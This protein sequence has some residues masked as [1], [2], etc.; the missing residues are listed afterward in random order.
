M[1]RTAVVVLGMHRSGT[2]A[3]A[4]LLHRDGAALPRSVMP[5]ADDNPTGFSESTRLVDLADEILA[6]HGTS[7]DGL[8]RIP[9]AWFASSAGEAWAGRYADALTEEFPGEG[10]VVIKDPRL[11]RLVPLLVEACDRAGFAPRFA[12][13]L[14]HPWAV[15][16]SLEARNGWRP[17]RGLAQWMTHTLAA[18]AGTRGRRRALV[19]YDALVDDPSAVARRLRRTLDVQR[20]RSAADVPAPDELVRPELRHH[21]E[22][23]GRPRPLRAFEPWIGRCW[24]AL[25]RLEE[26]DEDA[27]REL[28]R[29]RRVVVRVERRLTPVARD[30]EDETE[31]E[32]RQREAVQANLRHAEHVVDD[33][34]TKIRHREVRLEEAL[35]ERERV[36]SELDALAADR[37]EVQ[38]HLRF[39]ER[40]IARLEQDLETLRRSWSMRLTRPLRWLGRRARRAARMV[41]GKARS[42]AR[43]AFRALPLPD[44]LRRAIRG[45]LAR[46]RARRR[47]DEDRAA[48]ERR[49]RGIEGGILAGAPGGLA[50]DLDGKEAKEAFRRK[51]DAELDRFLD[52]AATLR[53]PDPSD[54]PALSVLLVLHDQAALTLACLRALAASEFRDFEVVVVDNAS[55]DRTRELL[56]R[57][58]PVR[59]VLSDENLHFLRGA[60]LAAD[61]A[62]G[63]HLLFL[64]NDTR[65]APSALG[66][67]LR[68]FGEE[69]RVGVVGARLILPDGRLQEAGSIVWSDGSCLGYGRGGDPDD[70][71]WTFRRDV[72]YC[73][74]AFLLTPRW[75][76]RELGGFDERFAPAYYE[77]TDYCMRVRAAGYRVVFEPGVTVA[78]FEFGSSSEEDG[79]ALQERNRGRF[80]RKHRTRLASHPEPR[81]E[82]PL[83]ARSA[84]R[85]AP[86]ILCIDDRFPHRELGSGFPRANDLVHDMVD[87][88]CEVTIYATDQRHE[89]P[90]ELRADLPPSVECLRGDRGHDLAAVLEERQGHADVVV[91]SRPHNMRAFDEVVRGRPEVFGNQRV[92]YDAEALFTLR[93]AARRRVLGDP[94]DEAE[95]RAMLADEVALAERA[96]A[97]L[98][99]N[100]AEARH[101]EGHGAEVFVVGHALRP[102]PGE[103]GFEERSGMLFV[104]AFHGDDDGP[105][106]DSVRWFAGEVWPRIRARRDVGDVRFRIVGRDPGPAVAALDRI[107]GVEVV[108]PVDRLGPAYGRARVCVVPTRFAAGMPYKAHEAAAR[109]VPMVTT[110]LIAEQLGWTHDREILVADASDPEAFADRCVQ[111]HADAELWAR[112]RRGALERVE[113]ECSPERTRRELLRA[114]GLDEEQLAGARPWRVAAEAEAKEASTVAGR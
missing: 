68:V 114:L 55:T 89:P 76:F 66:R 96:D 11:C 13:S 32:R 54:P 36:R 3:L 93:K 74:G 19:C 53:L 15:A 9:P 60:A 71:R 28:D 104:G 112:L 46:R 92:V 81:P 40:R 105:N 43:A 22:P 65:V 108:G 50:A 82:N 49:R 8:G 20:P 111:L 41:R 64:N 91:V 67:A 70:P 44:R 106:A 97:V 86:R 30:L 4:A 73:S 107:D 72:H 84:R 14:R 103:A 69:E 79:T 7:W 39:A 1:A 87:S 52:G 10:P 63:R 27:L 58:E 12:L 80:V 98:A 85:E 47:A 110:R 83:L 33:L 94:L 24:E 57:V 25:R 26:G 51:A 31:A 34:E 21:L 35:G 100:P 101:F 109:G 2:S 56:S 62:R 48:R 18:E 77:D 17:E 5:P 102:D 59:T 29:I 99:V 95:R 38:K 78:H 23:D 42:A 61:R 88:G 45:L 6:E 113:D 75:L 90:E 37:E 16:R